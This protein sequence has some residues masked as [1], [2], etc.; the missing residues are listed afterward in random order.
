MFV[1]RCSQK[2]NAKLFYSIFETEDVIDPFI[3][4]ERVEKTFSIDL[5][6]ED[7]KELTEAKTYGT[8]RDFVV[9]SGRCIQPRQL[10]EAL[11]VGSV[12]ALEW[13][14]LPNKIVKGKAYLRPLASSRLGLEARFGD[15]VELEVE[16]D[17]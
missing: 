15:Y 5:S 16:I 12:Y 10:P 3:E 1:K 11:E 14:A 17:R 13:E 9:L 8:R 4:P 6:V 7:V 2:S